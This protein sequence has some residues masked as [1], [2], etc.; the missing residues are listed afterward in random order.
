MKL[1]P[2]G[3]NLWTAQV[4]IHGV[5][6]WRHHRGRLDERLGVVG[7]KLEKTQTEAGVISHM[8]QTEAVVIS[9]MEQTEERMVKTTSCRNE[10][11]DDNTT[12]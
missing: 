10:Q 9:H 5:A 12:N 7:T 3:D 11:L 4:E 6:V 8:E 2:F 1:T